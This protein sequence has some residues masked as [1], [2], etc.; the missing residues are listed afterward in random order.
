[1]PMMALNITTF[2]SAMVQASILWMNQYSHLK[3][4]SQSP[5]FLQA[6]FNW[7]NIINLISSPEV[8]VGWHKHHSKMLQDQ[9][10]SSFFDA[11]VTWTGSSGCSLLNIP[12]LLIPP[13]LLTLNFSNRHGWT[14][15]CHAWSI[16]QAMT[17][18]FVIR[19]PFRV[20]IRIPTP[21]HPR[22]LV[23]TLIRNLI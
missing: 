10:F 9:N 8:A 3:N 15:S 11:C 2:H 16:Y 17:S 23:S 18:P 20:V 5:F 1:M 12:S 19:D 22:P 4:C 21:M 14:H 7:L 6:Y 13:V